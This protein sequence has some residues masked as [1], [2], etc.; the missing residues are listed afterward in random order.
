LSALRLVVLGSAAGGG[1]PQWNCRCRVCSL[2][3]DGDPRVRPRTQSSIAISADGER[4][5]LVNCAPDVLRQIAATP[6]LQ[7]R[8]CLRGSPIAAVLLT[9]GDVDHTAGLLSLRES[10]PFALHATPQ[11][12][13]VLGGNAIFAA[14]DPGAVPRRP[15]ALD[16]PFEILP[17]VTTRAFTVPG[18]TPLYLEGDE[19][20]IGAEGE[21]TVGLEIRGGDSVAFYVP[22]CAGMTD[23]LRRRIASADLLLFDGTVWQDDE[24]I[25]AGVGSKTGRR[26]GHLAM[27]GPDGSLAALSDVALGR[28]VFIHINN[29]NPVLIET[30]DERRAVEAAGWEV[31][32]D[33]LE[34]AL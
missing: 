20:D 23:T 17:G 9:N 22:G 10:Q 21:M 8:G 2:A 18:K 28:R 1:V 31:A 29:T 15:M 34:F 25:A 13:A 32:H 11:L 19:P 6:A 4:W 24:L 7:P 12:H 3:W 27:S 5:V 30:S 14:L 16:E 26:M 33:G